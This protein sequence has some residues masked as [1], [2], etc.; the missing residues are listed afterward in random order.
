MNDYLSMCDCKSH[1][2]R[3]ANDSHASLTKLESRHV[4]VVLLQLQ[5]LRGGRGPGQVGGLS[6][7]QIREQQTHHSIR[8]RTGR[9]ICSN[10]FVLP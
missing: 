4:H 9:E 7:S 2:K 8:A 10:S 3:L 1:T 6:K 5:S